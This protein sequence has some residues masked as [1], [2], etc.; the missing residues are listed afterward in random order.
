MDEERLWIRRKDGRTRPCR[1]PLCFSLTLRSMPT[2][3][4]YALL[5][6]FLLLYALPAH[7]QRSAAQ[8]ASLRAADAQ[9]ADQ[10]A[11]VAMAPLDN[12]ALV[13][14]DAALD[15]GEPRP[16]QFAEPFEVQLSA[17]NS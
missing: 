16:F 17:Q 3:H 6:A 9:P 13:A 12:D 4:R 1:C 5:G 10:I 15:T 7:A 2:F 8:P 11:R 14:R